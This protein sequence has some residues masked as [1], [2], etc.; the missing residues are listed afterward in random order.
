[1]PKRLKAN[2]CESAKKQY[3]E[4]TKNEF[5]NVIKPVRDKT[6]VC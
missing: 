3:Y 1:M 4:S 5:Y 6:D 2:W